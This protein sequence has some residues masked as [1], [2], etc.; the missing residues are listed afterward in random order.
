MST[1]QNL[2]PSPVLGKLACRVAT[3]QSRHLANWLG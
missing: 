1:S 3:Q 2:R